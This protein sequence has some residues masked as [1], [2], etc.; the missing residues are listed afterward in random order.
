[1]HH[2]IVSIV[3]LTLASCAATKMPYVSDG[4][5]RDLPPSPRYTTALL[6]LRDELPRHAEAGEFYLCQSREQVAALQHDLPNLKLKH[7]SET[8]GTPV[9]KKGWPISWS[10]RLSDNAPAI[11]VTIDIKSETPDLITATLWIGYQAPNL[12]EVHYTFRRQGSSWIILRREQ[13]AEIH[14]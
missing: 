13:E 12:T 4:E 3:L 1:M 5:P 2:F 6:A 14:I 9:P 7:A 8:Y 11:R 10:R